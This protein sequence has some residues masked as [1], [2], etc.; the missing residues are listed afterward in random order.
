M[1]LLNAV[2]VDHNFAVDSLHD[3]GEDK[4]KLPYHPNVLCVSHLFQYSLHFIDENFLVS[5]PF[6][7][8]WKIKYSPFNSALNSELSKCD[9]STLTQLR[10]IYETAL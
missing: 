3:L 8:L 7:Q 10:N 1:Y 4:G 5:A 6:N 9:M 2:L